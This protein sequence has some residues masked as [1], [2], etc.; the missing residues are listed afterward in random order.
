ME[1]TSIV[2]YHGSKAHYRVSS[3]DGR[4]FQAALIQYEGKPS[5]IP[6]ARIVFYKEEATT[7]GPSDSIDLIHELSVS[8]G[9]RDP[10]D[11]A[12][13]PARRKKRD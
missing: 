9:Q 10:L 13:R 11:E 4:T 8:S 12:L 6:P 7:L 2:L 3:P 5:D 1:Y